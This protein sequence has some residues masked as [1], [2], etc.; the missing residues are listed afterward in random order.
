MNRPSLRHH[1]NARIRVWPACE[2][3]EPALK[4]GELRLLAEAM[5][6]IKRDQIVPQFVRQRIAGT[7]AAMAL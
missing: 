7:L 5:L 2:D 4:R 1:V 6:A 3:M